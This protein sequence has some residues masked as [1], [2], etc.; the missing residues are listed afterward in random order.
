VIWSIAAG[1]VLGSIPSADLVAR[2][3]GLDLRSAGSGNPGTANALR[4]G[5]K[6]MAA[7]VL[8]LDLLKGAGA[9]L[10]GLAIAGD[11]AS[12]AAAVAAIAGQV[13]NPWFGFRGGKGLGVT[14]GTLLVA[15]P[16]ALAVVAPMIAALARPLRSS[17][18]ALVALASLFSA[19]VVWAI[20][21]WPTGWGVPADDGL[22]WYAIGIVAITAP[23]FLSSIGRGVP[24]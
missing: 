22:V 20:N 5:G 18:A 10:V 17:G 15:W 13:H 11:R 8:A 19:A 23:K 1:F 4:V 6:S 2:A 3:R 7:T 16:W 21:D 12:L 24:A 14:G 9:T